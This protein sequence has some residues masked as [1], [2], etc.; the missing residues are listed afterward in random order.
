MNNPEVGMPFTPSGAWDLIDRL[1]QDGQPL[2]EVVLRLPP[3]KIAYE[4]IVAL[5]PGRPDLYIKLHLG[6]AG[7]V[8]G[9]SFHYSER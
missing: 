5:E 2:I 6:A 3:G 9:R 7:K 1:L 8:V 4:M